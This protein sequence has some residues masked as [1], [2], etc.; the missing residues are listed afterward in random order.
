MQSGI[1]IVEAEEVVVVL[2]E[3]VEAVVEVSQG[4]QELSL[5]SNAIKVPNIQTCHLEYGQDVR[6]IINGGKAVT[7][8]VSQIPAPGRMSLPSVQQNNE[9]LTSST[10]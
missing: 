1:L 5:N 9:K 2:A 7:F 10:N 6:C 4:A 8:V 3:I